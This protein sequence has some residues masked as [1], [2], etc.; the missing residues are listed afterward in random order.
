M[1]S[2]QR[3]ETVVCSILIKTAALVLTDPATSIK[4][5][6]TNPVGTSVVTATAM[7]KD[8]TGTYH[9]DYSPASDA[10]LGTYKVK[11]TAVDGTRTTIQNDTFS[12]E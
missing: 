10:V 11:Y 5:D 1:K 7:T 3:A 12:L 9:Y 4:I 2:F 6:I 8:T